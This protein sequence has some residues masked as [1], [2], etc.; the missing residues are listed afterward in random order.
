MKTMT[1]ELK[2]Y[3]AIIAVLFGMFASIT[4][5]RA[6]SSLLIQQLNQEISQFNDNSSR[7]NQSSTHIKKASQYLEKAKKLE[8]TSREFAYSRSM[9]AL[10]MAKDL[11]SRMKIAK[12][13]LKASDEML[14]TINQLIQESEQENKSGQNIFKKTDSDQII[15]Q[16]VAQMKG[17]YNAIRALSNQQNFKLRQ[18]FETLNMTLASNELNQEVNSTTNQNTF[19]TLRNETEGVYFTIKAYINGLHAKANYLKM[20]AVG[21]GVQEVVNRARVIISE[22]LH[23]FDLNGEEM[24]GY[25]YF[26]SNLTP[27][28]SVVGIKKTDI[29]DFDN[30]I[31]ALAT[32]ARR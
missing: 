20:I 12:G 30:R 10:E 19:L 24:T 32:G 28:R 27:H 17:L 29:P 2:V 23:A 7:L 25:H 15:K 8:P 21:G 14:S 6:E 4:E 5:S 13:S 9:Y 16:K 18:A 1:N 26:A 22:N 11:E 3:F 31:D